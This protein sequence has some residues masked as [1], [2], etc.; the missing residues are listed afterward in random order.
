MSN[1]SHHSLKKSDLS[2]SLVILAKLPVFTAF[3][4]FYTQELIAPVALPPIALFRE[5]WERFALITLYKRATI[6]EILPSFITKEQPW[7]IHS[8]H[9]LQSATGGIRYFSRANQT[10]SLSLTKTS[11][12][13]EKPNSEF[14][15]LPYRDSVTTIWPLIDMFNRYLIWLLFCEDNWIE[16]SIFLLRCVITV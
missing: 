11:D 10:F 2:D 8:R 7:A 6:S 9:S 4:P 16:T 14:P 1:C 15:T 5:W 13:L 3:P 12:S